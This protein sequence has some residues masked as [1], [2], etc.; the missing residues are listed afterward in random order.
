[1][2]ATVTRRSFRRVRSGG[3]HTYRALRRHRAAAAVVAVVAA[4]TFGAAAVSAGEVP[5]TWHPPA[6]QGH[7]HGPMA[8][9]VPNWMGP[10]RN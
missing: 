6:M 4:A 8:N 10:H 7:Q 2:A 3:R 5:S 1:M 9:G